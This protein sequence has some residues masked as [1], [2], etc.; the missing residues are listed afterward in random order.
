MN[1]TVSVQLHSGFFFRNEERVSSIANRAIGSVDVD[2][3]VTFELA[4]KTEFLQRL[5]AQSSAASKQ[6][7]WQADT[8]IVFCWSARGCRSFKCEDINNSEYS[9]RASFSN[10]DLLYKAQRYQMSSRSHND[11][12]CHI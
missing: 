7:N 12:A 1:V 8:T 5:Q 10:E 6:Q 9:Y 11:E 4:V 2:S 3:E